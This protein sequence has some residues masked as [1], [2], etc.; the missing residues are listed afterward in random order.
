MDPGSGLG[1]YRSIHVYILANLTHI[2]A[3]VSSYD[4]LLLR[5]FESLGGVKRVLCEVLIYSVIER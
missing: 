3:T 4:D 1:I 5:I 2:F